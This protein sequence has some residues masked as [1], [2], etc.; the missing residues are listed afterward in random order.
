MS[1]RLLEEPL[2]KQT[3]ASLLQALALQ[4]GILN[5][6]LCFDCI[7]FYFCYLVWLSSKEITE[8]DTTIQSCSC[9]IGI[10][11]IKQGT[12]QQDRHFLRTCLVNKEVIIQQIDLTNPFTCQTIKSAKPISLLD[13]LTPSPP[14]KKSEQKPI[15][16]QD[17]FPYQ[18]VVS[19]PCSLFLWQG[20]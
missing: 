7:N 6:I 8:H 14:W 16:S 5:I 1:S 4:V 2:T 10:Y 20:S 17:G 13:Y 12:K 15:F 11:Q 19:F 9:V 18:D 3:L